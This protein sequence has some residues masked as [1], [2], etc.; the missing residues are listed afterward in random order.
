MCCSDA[1]WSRVQAPDACDRVHLWTVLGG[2]QVACRVTEDL[3]H[4]RAA[5]LIPPGIANRL[6]TDVFGRAGSPSVW[7]AASDCAMPLLGV[8]SP[9]DSSASRTICTRGISS[10]STANLPV[11]ITTL[12]PDHRPTSSIG[13]GVS[14]LSVAARS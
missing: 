1:S 11:P 13:D 4:A 7:A 14:A 10:P 3:R 6:M 2:G 8:L 5:E 9:T 12:M